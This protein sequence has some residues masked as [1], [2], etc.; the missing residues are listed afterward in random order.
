MS[1]DLQRLFPE[2]RGF[3]IRNLKYMRQF[4]VTYPDIEF[5]QQPVA[6]LPWG[7]IIVLIQMVKDSSQGCGLSTM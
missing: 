5:V 7:H 1:H 4:V 3:S 2:T 6:Q